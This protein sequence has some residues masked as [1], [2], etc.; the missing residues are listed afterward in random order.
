MD[1][2]TLKPNGEPWDFSRAADRALA[3]KMVR[4]KRPQ[5]IIAAPPCTPFSV[6]NFN[7][8]YPRMTAE[9]VQAK[10]EEGRV[11]LQFVCRLY[12]YQVKHGGYFLH[13]HPRTA[14]SWREP[15]VQRLLKRSDVHVAK[16][17][18]CEFGA[19]NTVGLQWSDSA[20]EGARLLKP[21]RFMS[22]SPQMLQR[23]FRTCKRDHVHQPLLGGRAA[24]ASFYP[25]DLIKAILHGVSDTEHISSSIPE[26]AKT[27]TMFH[28]VCPCKLLM[29][30]V[31]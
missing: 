17:D 4:E 15:C 24:S 7:M 10:L 30:T 14:R 28:L 22:N 27:N 3:M 31:L 12:R 11:H 25:F 18:Q 26:M 20:G 29:T 8:N 2:R 19:E 23:L 9:E 5:W 16:C 6:L 21:T 1:L 13:E